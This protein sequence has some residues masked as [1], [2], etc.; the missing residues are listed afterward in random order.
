MDEIVTFADIGVSG[1]QLNYLINEE[2]SDFSDASWQMDVSKKLDT[3]VEQKNKATPLNAK[4]L[5]IYT[6]TLKKLGTKTGSAL[7]YFQENH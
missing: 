1:E 6:E 2:I 7:L 5:S 3:F 4:S